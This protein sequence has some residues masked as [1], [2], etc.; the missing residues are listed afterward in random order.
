MEGAEK[1]GADNKGGKG[2]GG[3]ARGGKARGKARGKAPGDSPSAYEILRAQNIAENNAVLN[4]LGISPLG[5]GKSPKKRKENGADV[6]VKLKRARPASYPVPQVA[7]P[8]A[9][10]IAIHVVAHVVAHVAGRSLSDAC[11]ADL[12]LCYRLSSIPLLRQRPSL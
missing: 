10:H 11:S 6:V 5:T 9:A 3:R 1:K 7:T 2:R 4:G 12:H 8:V